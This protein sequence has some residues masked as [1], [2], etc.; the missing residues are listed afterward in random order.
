MRVKSSLFL[1]VSGETSKMQTL[2]AAQLKFCITFALTR[3][4]FL[5]CYQVLD[6]S[7]TCSIGYEN[8]TSHVFVSNSENWFGQENRQTNMAT[9][10]SYCFLRV[11]QN[12]KQ[13]NTPL[14]NNLTNK[15][16]DL[17]LYNRKKWLNLPQR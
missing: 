9:N 4:K 17:P 6:I 7:A 13:L 12:T 14:N 8:N 11:M 10:I 3:T 16:S 1:Y 2:S 5:S 15:P